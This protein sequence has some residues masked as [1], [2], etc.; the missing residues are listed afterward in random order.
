MK[1]KQATKTEMAKENR[2]YCRRRAKQNKSEQ[3][4]QK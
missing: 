1:S 2:V 3:K 4:Y